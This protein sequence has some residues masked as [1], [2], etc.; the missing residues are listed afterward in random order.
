MF[1]SRLFKR[2]GFNTLIKRNMSNQTNFTPDEIKMIVGCGVVCLIC[3]NIGLYFAIK[4][5]KT[6]MG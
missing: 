6:R 1:N 4:T 5:M 2:V 3:N